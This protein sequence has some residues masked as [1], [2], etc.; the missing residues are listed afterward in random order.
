LGTT[1]RL[2]KGYEMG[3]DVSTPGLTTRE[4]ILEMPRLLDVK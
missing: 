2:S 1:A 4:A 3:P